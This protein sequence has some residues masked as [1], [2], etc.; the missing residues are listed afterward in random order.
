M[1]TL[2]NAVLEAIPLNIPLPTLV[3]VASHL[4]TIFR[5][6]LY[7]INHA[8]GLR[9]AE[10]EFAYAGV[11]D[12]TQA[13][14]YALLHA[15]LAKSTTPAFHH[16]YRD[17]LQSSARV[18]QTVH[19]YQHGT[20]VWQ[21]QIVNHAYGRAGMMVSNGSETCYVADATLAC[22]AEGFMATL[23]SEIC[24]AL[25]ERLQYN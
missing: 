5:A 10:V 24:A 1:N 11:A 17:W 22:P 20:T 25:A 14:A 2:R 18:A 15:H 23:L 4:A 6:Q 13:Y 19:I 21:V 7:A 9:P 3:S 8:I 12:V 16:V